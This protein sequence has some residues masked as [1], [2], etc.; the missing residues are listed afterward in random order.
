[1]LGWLCGS[2]LNFMYYMHFNSVDAT[3]K[4][5]LTE[6]STQ[7][8]HTDKF[9]APSCRLQSKAYTEVSE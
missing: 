3:C 7:K 8:Q 1:M 2:S 4:L 5:K 9:S 6:I